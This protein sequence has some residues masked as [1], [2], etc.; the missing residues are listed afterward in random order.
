MQCVFVVVSRC[1]VDSH[2]PGLPA[3]QLL[4]FD[5]G[6]SASSAQIKLGL[7]YEVKEKRFTVFVMQISNC[8][9]LS[10]PT[11]QNM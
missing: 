7:K 5:D 1:C 3:E 6:S 4:G 11:N 8:N 2:R 10:L 9:A